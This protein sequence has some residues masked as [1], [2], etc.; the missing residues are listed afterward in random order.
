MVEGHEHQE[1]GIL[2]LCLFVLRWQFDPILMGGLHGEGQQ[3]C[4]SM[5]GQAE[6]NLEVGK[7]PAW[8]VNL[9]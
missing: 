2:A 9:H 8:L 6:S 3:G 5:V 4:K 7:M 1:T